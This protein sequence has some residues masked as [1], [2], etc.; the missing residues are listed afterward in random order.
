LHAAAEREA[1]PR[2][3]PPGTTYGN[4][5]VSKP[6]IS[7]RERLIKDRLSE[8]AWLQSQLRDADSKK[9]SVQGKTDIHSFSGM[10][11]RAGVFR[12]DRPRGE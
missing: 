3:I 10:F 5:T 8:D 1:F 12:Q 9:F 4:I 2:V 6:R 7:T 11:A